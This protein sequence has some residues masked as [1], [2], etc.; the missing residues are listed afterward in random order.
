MLFKIRLRCGSHT[1]HRSLPDLHGY[2]VLFSAAGK[3]LFYLAD[4]LGG[5]QAILAAPRGEFCVKVP[6]GIFAIFDGP[7]H[8]MVLSCLAGDCA[9]PRAEVEKMA[10]EHLARV[11]RTCVVTHEIPSRRPIR[12]PSPAETCV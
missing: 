4:T 1:Y 6:V 3:P 10:R 2:L 9:T 11:A 5:A 8:D 7:L 12:T